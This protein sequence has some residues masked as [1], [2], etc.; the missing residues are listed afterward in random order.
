MRGAKGALVTAL[1]GVLT[2]PL[3]FTLLLTGGS[4]GAAFPGL[5]SGSVPVVFLQWVLKAAG[6][7]PQVPAPLIA[8]QIEA[9]S[10]WNPQAESHDAAG[11]VLARGISQFIDPTW[12]TWGR[13]ESGDGSASPYDPADAIMAQGRFMCALARDIAGLPGDLV[14]NMLAA[15]NSG[16][17]AVR[18]YRGVPPF[19]E[20]RAYIARIQQLMATKYTQVGAPPGPQ[21]PA[22]SFGVAVIAAAHRWAGTPYVWGGG[23]FH[24]PTSGGFDCSGLTLHA[25]YQASGGRIRLPHLAALQATMGAPVSR[26]AMRPGDLIAFSL[27][28]G[29]I[30]HIGIYVGNGQMLHAPR[31]GEVV[32]VADLKVPYYQRVPWVIRRFG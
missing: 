1:A 19:A 32:R 12:A 17:G 27:H 23:D 24:G 10:N 6:V 3:I 22:S 16:P 5:R 26:E 18:R 13:D 31:T 7:C 29:R 9:E 28:G 20:T 4:G 8:A 30:D 11:N 14:T 2:V 15:Y 21:G 25:V